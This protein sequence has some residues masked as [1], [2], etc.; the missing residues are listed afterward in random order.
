MVSLTVTRRPFQSPVACAHISDTAPCVVARPSGFLE[1]G[2]VEDAYL[3][4]IFTDLL[5]RQT[6]RTDLGGE[7]GRGADLTTGRAQVDDLYLI[8][9]EL[10]CYISYILAMA[11]GAQINRTILTHG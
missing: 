7:R 5:R 9:V 11:A 10:G 2:R 3:C 4:D 6:E 1:G 8:G